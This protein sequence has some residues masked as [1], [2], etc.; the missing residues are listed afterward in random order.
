PPPP[1]AP[2]P[3][4]FAFLSP[5][6]ASASTL[7]AAL[8]FVSADASF[9][10]DSILLILLPFVLLALL[11]L[12]YVV[13]LSRHKKASSHELAPLNRVGSVTEPLAPEGAV[14]VG[15]ELWR[16]RTRDGAHVPR[17]RGN[18]CVVGARGH[19]LEVEPTDGGPHT[20]P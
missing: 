7:H 1:P 14:L 15:G 5:R 18:V 11:A 16:A 13:L 8:P 9:V 12:L 6:S 4:R 19:L 10:S 20:S 3:P 17:G 2:V